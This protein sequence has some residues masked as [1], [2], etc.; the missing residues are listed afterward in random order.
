MKRS[1]SISIGGESYPCSPTMGA[2]LRFKELTGKEVTEI[3]AGS[4]S[5]LAKY[6][7]CC[8][9]SGCKREGKEF[10][11]T[12]MDFADMV[13]IDEM[14]AWQRSVADNEDVETSEGN[15]KKSS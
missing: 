13:G 9:V 7:W 5:D 2:M 15:E 1:V 6:L 8:I 12:M 10:G 4:L 11:L 3:N 14:T